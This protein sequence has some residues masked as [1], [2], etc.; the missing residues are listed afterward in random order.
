L[1]EESESS[2]TVAPKE[3][4]SHALSRFAAT[5]IVGPMNNVDRH[6]CI[7]NGSSTSHA[8]VQRT[9]SG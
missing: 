2:I 9:K 3:R 1:K 7:S 8:G 4:G 5:R 6:V